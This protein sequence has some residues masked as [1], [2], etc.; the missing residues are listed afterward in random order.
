[1]APGS[2]LYGESS[3]TMF[4]RGGA[5]KPVPSNTLSCFKV[6]YCLRCK[7]QVLQSV[8]S[9]GRW[10]IICPH[11]YDGRRVGSGADGPRPGDPSTPH[12]VKARHGDM[13]PIKAPLHYLP[14]LPTHAL[15]MVLSGCTGAG[16]EGPRSELPTTNMGAGLTLDIELLPLAGDGAGG[17][18]ADE[19]ATVHGLHAA[20][21]Q[22]PRRLVRLVQ[23][24][25]QQHLPLAFSSLGGE[26]GCTG[27]RRRASGR[28]RRCGPR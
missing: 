18:F 5:A 19:A 20:D 23:G 9:G 28:R 16:R 7:R 10:V 3:G 1:M 17:D 25:P 15:M 8:R 27:G 11:F 13:P 26:E 21:H 14:P 2:T 22:V 12:L 4:T 24:E 6:T